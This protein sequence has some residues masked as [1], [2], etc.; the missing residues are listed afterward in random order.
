VAHDGAPDDDED[1]GSRSEWWTAAD[2][3]VREWE[4]AAAVRLLLSSEAAELTRLV[5]EGLRQAFERG[6]RTPRG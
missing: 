3:I 1:T 2:R 6:A 5:A 4:G